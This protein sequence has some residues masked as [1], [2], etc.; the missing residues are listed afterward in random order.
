MM[1]MRGRFATLLILLVPCG[2]A[3]YTASPASAGLPITF[4]H[5]GTSR[6]FLLDDVPYSGSFDFTITAFADVSEREELPSGN[7]WFIDHLSAMIEIDGVG[8]FGIL[9]PTRS[10]VGN[11]SE[12]VGF[13]HAGAAGRTLLLGPTHADFRDWD[14]TTSIGPR[15]SSNGVL[16]QWQED[17]L[18]TTGGILIFDDEDGSP[19]PSPPK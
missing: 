6:G 17:P 15:S 18:E 12:V 9:T 14:M 10:F 11:A 8:S 19:P 3:L 2:V 5:E 16:L 13:A 7:G 4:V 1:M